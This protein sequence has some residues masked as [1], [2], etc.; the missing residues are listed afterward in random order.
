LSSNEKAQIETYQVAD[1]GFATKTE[2]TRVFGTLLY[3]APELLKDG[4]WT[5]QELMKTDLWSAGILLYYMI[6]IN[7]NCHSY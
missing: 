7:N 3:M 4:Q 1:L 5:I 6:L 2:S